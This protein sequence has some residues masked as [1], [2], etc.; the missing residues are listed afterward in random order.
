MTIS[1][2]LFFDIYRRTTF[3]VET[4]ERVEM[5]VAPSAVINPDGGLIE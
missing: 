5:G 3:G 4:T 2:F 1:W